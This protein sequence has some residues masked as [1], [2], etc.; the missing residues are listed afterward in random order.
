[1]TSAPVSEAI[2]APRPIPVRRPTLDFDQVRS[3]HW[4]GGDPFLTQL[5][6]A[7]S[8]TFPEGERFFM[9]A[10]RHYQ[11][12]ITSPALRIE[13]TRFL[14]QEG[15]HARAH[16]AFNEWIGTLGFET[17]SIERDVREG[18]ERVRQ[19]R[20]PRFQLGMTCALE[21][22]TA[23]M[24][25]LLLNN[26]EM[27]ESM[28][29][30]I[31]RLWVWHALEET[32]HKAVAFDTYFAIGGTYRTRALTMVVATLVFIITVALHQERLMHQDP[33]A[34]GPLVRLRGLCRLWVW[35]GYFLPL[36]PA[37]FDY[38]RPSFH[39]WQREPRRGLEGFRR[40]LEA[41]VVVKP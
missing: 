8:L 28:D 17:E 20:T 23:M 15:L 27:R 34:A 41:A 7:L 25:E 21:H 2:R 39:P 19:R 9:D 13:I 10:V 40:E 11:P 6:H 4:F 31:R 18:L 12:R 16:T 14:G 24:A 35:P 37:Y 5:G 26:E 38:F 30:A 1:M 22:F 33:D 29:P 32:E 3:R 36:L